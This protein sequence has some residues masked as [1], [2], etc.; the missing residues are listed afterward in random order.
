MTSRNAGGACNRAVQPAVAAERHDPGRSDRRSSGRSRCAATSVATTG[1]AAAL[2]RRSVNGLFTRR[3]AR[4]RGREPLRPNTP[5]TE[6]EQ[7]ARNC[8]TCSR[9]VNYAPPC[10]PGRYGAGTRGAR[11]FF[12]GT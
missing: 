9:N 6:G 5:R 3:A 11:G 10:K 1:L 2:W 4:P 12:S 8:L 7:R